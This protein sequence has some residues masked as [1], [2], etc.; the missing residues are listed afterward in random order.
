MVVKEKMSKNTTSKHI[1][2]IKTGDII[3]GRMV[4]D[5]K[6]VYGEG[7]MVDFSNNTSQYYEWNEKVLVDNPMVDVIRSKSKVKN[8]DFKHGQL[9]TIGA[10][11]EVIFEYI[12]AMSDCPG[13]CIVRNVSNNKFD[14]YYVEELV[15]ASVKR[16]LLDLSN[17][18]NVAQDVKE[19]WELAGELKELAEQL[20]D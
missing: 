2:S 3:Q 17:K 15:S 4:A 19:A 20:P 11:G 9:V 12:S 1:S 7:A 18:L 10:D 14:I 8:H 5:V 6:R 13:Q 16:Q